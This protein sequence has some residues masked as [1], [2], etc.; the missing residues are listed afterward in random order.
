MNRRTFFT[1]TF[2]SG[3]FAT[4]FAPGESLQSLV[5]MAEESER[6]RERHRNRL[7]MESCSFGHRFNVLTRVCDCGMSLK[8][9]HLQRPDER[10][11][12]QTLRRPT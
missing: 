11:V 10:S 7:D 4:T 1:S 9:Y 12:C 3:A 6:L 2:V 8:Q 5:A